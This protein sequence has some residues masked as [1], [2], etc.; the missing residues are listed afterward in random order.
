MGGGRSRQCRTSGW[1]LQFLVRERGCD[2]KKHPTPGA[3]GGG[4]GAH[5]NRQ[6]V[7][8]WE[9]GWA[10]T[11]VSDFGGVR[12][13]T[14]SLTRA[15]RQLKGSSWEA[16]GAGGSGAGSAGVMCTQTAV[17]ECFWAPGAPR[18][19]QTGSPHLRPLVSGATKRREGAWFDRLCRDSHG[20]QS[21]S[22]QGLSGDGPIWKRRAREAR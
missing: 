5:R 6:D 16:G 20:G 12:A 10:E 15:G 19:A 17:P 21:R 2:G 18:G 13:H 14:E 1:G 4:A 3:P 22:G 9:G 8:G 11:V 7:P